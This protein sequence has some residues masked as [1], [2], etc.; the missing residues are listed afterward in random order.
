MGCTGTSALILESANSR[1][2][3]YEKDLSLFTEKS[4]NSTCKIIL[5]DGYGSGF[6]C[7]IPY[8]RDEITYLN[9]LLTC[10]H[11]LEK[12]IVLSN[13]K[14]INI[15]IDDVPKIITLKKTRKKW[16]NPELDYSCIEI[17]EE[18]NIDNDYYQIDDLIL[19]KDYVKEKFLEKEYNKI[20]IFATMLGGERGYDGGNI[21]DIGEKM[22]I[23]SCNTHPGC[24]GGVIVNKIK[25]SVIGMHIGSK[26]NSKNE[27][28]ENVGIFIKNIIDDIKKNPLLEIKGDKIE[29]KMEMNMI[30]EINIKYEYIHKDRIDF[31][32]GYP[33]FPQSYIRLFGEKFVE[34]NKDFCKIIIKGKENDLAQ[35]YCIEN[36]QLE[37]III[38]GNLKK[39]RK[40]KILKIKKSEVKYKEIKKI[41]KNKK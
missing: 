40:T 4:K 22:F 35:F 29:D 27:E 23:H 5:E 8:T 39:K 32:D 26:T 20:L 25:N 36:K 31:I 38:E 28:I 6:F 30:D 16:S 41:T 12:D 37:N 34:N 33:Q 19:K 21:R 9:V 13:D 2:V 15:I 18:D 1:G 3:F 24:S 10:E 17:K 14:D 11:V 7:R